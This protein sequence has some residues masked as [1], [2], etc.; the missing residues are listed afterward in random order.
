MHGRKV[1]VMPPLNLRVAI[2]ILHTRKENSR[3]LDFSAFAPQKDAARTLHYFLATN[4]SDTTPAAHRWDK[5][6]RNLICRRYSYQQ[7]V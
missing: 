3:E 6:L 7:S 1:C 4:A 2:G 5:S